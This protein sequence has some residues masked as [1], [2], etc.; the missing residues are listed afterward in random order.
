MNRSGS[1]FLKKL[2]ALL[3]CAALLCGLPS[4]ASAEE[5]PEGVLD[6]TALTELVE[7]FLR[8]QSIP[9]DRVGIGF[10]YLATGEEWFY[11]PD[12]WF[13]PASMYKVPLM[14]DL[15]E[16]VSA[17]TVEK[18]VQIGGLPLDT[19]FEY[20]IVYSNN[21]YAHLVRKFLDGDE[22]WREEAKQYARLEEYDSRYMDYCYFS[23]R[24]MTQVLETLY[25][26]PARFPGVMEN[27]L[28][29]DQGH[30]FRLTDEMHVYDVA[31]KYGSYLD[32]E[33]NDWNHN[34][35]VIFTPKPFVLTVMTK[36]VGGHEYVI[37]SFARLFKDYVLGLKEKV[38][39]YE[40]EQE[41]I[42]AVQAQ[43]E[44]ERAE[45]ERLEAERQLQ[46]RQAEIRQQAE[47]RETQE[48]ASKQLI[49]SLAA[50]FAG[51]LALGGLGSALVARHRKK[52]RY[53]GYRRRFEEELRQE[54]LARQ[55][56][57]P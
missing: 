8:E 9:S 29:A 4:P 23:P 47:D 54:E 30:Y 40:R 2:S 16:R 10:C 17:G 49:Y 57:R 22:V 46:A 56:R 3:V 50:T 43:E 52:K 27:M 55:R 39:V 41:E 20:I 14:M 1:N 42:A 31:Q 25:A 48:R 36:N 44:A 33:N 45:A 35:G 5:A 38:A 32:M 51:L 6:P 7:G 11:N 26:D 18:D 37:G 13:Y 28:R 21:D 34:A 53:E 24:Y 19:V 12:T 15:A